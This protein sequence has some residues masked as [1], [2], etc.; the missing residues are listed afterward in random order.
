MARAG[1]D[2]FPGGGGIARGKHGD[3]QLRAHILVEA[4]GWQR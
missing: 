3:E 2:Q 4:D 1:I